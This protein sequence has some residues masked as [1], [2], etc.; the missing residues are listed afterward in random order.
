R[1][2][3]NIMGIKQHLNEQDQYKRQLRK[4]IG[5]YRFLTMAILALFILIVLK[6]VEIQVVR[7]QDYQDQAKKLRHH[8]AVLFNRGRI[9]DRNGVILAQDSSVYNIYAHPRYYY[10]KTPAE[11][12]QLLSPVLKV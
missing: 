12:A 8:T 5:R 10:K 3:E 6:L 1:T 2:R 11:L 4:R 9:L 7:A